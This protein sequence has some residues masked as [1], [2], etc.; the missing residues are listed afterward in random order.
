MNRRRAL[1]VSS[2]AA[3]F[4]MP[5]HAQEAA[6]GKPAPHF[7]VPDSANRDRQLS[8][9][10]GKIVVLEWSSPSC[11]FVRAQYQSGV[12]QE[13]QAEASRRGV[14]WLT[15]LST[16]P[17]RRDYLPA[18]KAAAFHRG[19]RGAS[20]ALLL[21][22]D[23]KMGKAYGAVVTPHLFIIGADGALAYAGGA[24]DKPTM[25][26][27]EVRASR[28]FVRAA[29]DDLAASR[30]VAVPTAPPFGCAIAYRG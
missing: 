19:R 22:D 17:S 29:L 15:V 1:L 25:N 21:D 2:L 7:R 8:E 11:P 16:Y 26:P 3:L 28:S 4:P 20:T 13:L 23:G 27:D 6:V 5:L 30:K 14:V 18:E 9:F 12:M 10:A 24:G